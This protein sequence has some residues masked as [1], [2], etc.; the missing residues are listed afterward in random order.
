[1]EFAERTGKAIMRRFYLV[2]HEDESG[3][4][5]TGVIAEGVLFSN[6]KCHISWLTKHT[7]LGIYP[8]PDEMMA[9]HGHDGKTI[10]VFVDD[11]PCTPAAIA[12]KI[13]LPEEPKPLKPASRPDYGIGL[14]F[15][16]FSEYEDKNPHEEKP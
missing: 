8:D 5:G 13:P 1:M 11:V 14:K 7:S 15:S 10:L 2:R 6:W 16:D 4:S 9:I 12:D 3:V